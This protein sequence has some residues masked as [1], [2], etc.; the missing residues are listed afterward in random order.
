MNTVETL[1]HEIAYSKEWGLP[2]D[3]D[4]DVLERAVDILAK[5]PVYED[6]G[7]LFVPGR[8]DA[9]IICDG[10]AGFSSPPRFRDDKW[11][12]SAKLDRVQWT[13]VWYSSREAAQAAADA[14]KRHYW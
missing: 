3:V 10:V 1:K 9:W 4:R 2:V 12:P 11:E 13:G 7:E 5:L 8:D 14:K 6:T